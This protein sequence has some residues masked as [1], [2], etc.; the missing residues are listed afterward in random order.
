MASST[1]SQW[2][3]ADEEV[4]KI[5]AYGPVPTSPTQN[6]YI[7]KLMPQISFGKPKSTS[8]ALN[9]SCICNDTKCKPAVSSR[10]SSKNYVTLS[11]QANRSFKHNY[12]HPGDTVQVEVRNDNPDDMYLSTKVDP[13]TILP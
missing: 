9:K 2:S 11:T 8:V 6:L 3:L 12:F 7:T 13:S 10:I 1:V 4:A 5:S